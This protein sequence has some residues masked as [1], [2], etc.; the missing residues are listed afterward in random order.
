LIRAGTDPGEKKKDVK[1]EAVITHASTFEIVGREW[2]EGFKTMVAIGQYE[3]L[4]RAW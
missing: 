3:K 4:W 1:L 2:M